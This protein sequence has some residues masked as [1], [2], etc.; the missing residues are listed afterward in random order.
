MRA[1]VDVLARSIWT[2]LGAVVALNVVSVVAGVA[3]DLSLAGAIGLY[4]VV[5]WTLLFLVLPLGVRTQAEEG[6][7]AD[8]TDP[9][10]PASP[11][12]RER[13]IWTSVVSTAVFV[14]VAAFFPLAGL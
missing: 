8:G 2:T 11:A 7:V 13:A 6:V 3:F 4:F 14:V 5:W 10:A 9:G 1:L 12:L